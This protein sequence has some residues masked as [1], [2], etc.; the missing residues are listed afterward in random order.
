MNVSFPSSP[1]I[2][3]LIPLKPRGDNEA[4]WKVTC[5]LLHQTL[6]SLLAQTVPN[7]MAFVA[8]HDRPDF[9]AGNF[10]SRIAFHQVDWPPP[11]SRGPRIDKSWK[12]AFAAMRAH[13][14]KPSYQMV[15]DADDLLRHDLVDV[16]NRYIG[17]SAIVFE[18]GWEFDLSLGRARR[19]DHLAALCGSTAAL[20]T[21]DFPLPAGRDWDEWNKVPWIHHGHNKIKSLLVSRNLSFVVPDERCVAYLTGHDAS[22]R[23]RHR[24]H[25]WKRWFV[26]HLIGRRIGADL[27]R[28]FSFCPETG[29]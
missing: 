18:R 3:F 1:A 13:E 2:A 8:G 9:L 20:S 5:D 25:P 12:I 17:S 14:A 29:V 26:F 24:I 4:S 15:L 23:Q 28:Q 21:S 6:G 16:V 10:D 11:H 7:W 22:L 19:C 27:A